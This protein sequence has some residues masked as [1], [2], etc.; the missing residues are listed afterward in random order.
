[1]N[2]EAA[3]KQVILRDDGKCRR[4]GRS[5]T[6]AHHRQLRGMGKTSGERMY[7]MASLILLCRDCHSWIHLHPSESYES[8]WLV[9]SWDD[10]GDVPVRKEGKYEF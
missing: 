3:R 4:C 7:D 10:P 6:D 2:W 8:G 1:V 5:G 9:H